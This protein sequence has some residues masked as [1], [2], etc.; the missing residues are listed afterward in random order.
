MT[1]FATKYAK[2]LPHDQAI[3]DRRHVRRV[4]QGIADGGLFG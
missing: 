1:V 3:H 4:A 2:E